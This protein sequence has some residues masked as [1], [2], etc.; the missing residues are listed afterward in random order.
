M[1][2]VSISILMAFLIS[3][4]VFGNKGNNGSFWII[5]YGFAAMLA[6]F[7]T[8]NLKVR[9]AAAFGS[10]AYSVLAIK[11]SSA[12]IA[13]NN[14]NT[15]AIQITGLIVAAVYCLSLVIFSTKR[16]RSDQSDGQKI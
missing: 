13:T 5:L 9:W 1:K 12:P 7:D 8:L 2:F 14:V 10:V 11:M 15:G 3:I 4:A 16:H 6:I